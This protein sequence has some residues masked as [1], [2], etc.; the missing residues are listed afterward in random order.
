[1][2]DWRWA[3]GAAFRIAWNLSTLASFEFAVSEEEEILYIELGQ[4]F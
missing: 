3:G 4:P 2:S 1:M